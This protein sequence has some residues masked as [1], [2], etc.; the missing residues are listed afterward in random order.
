M[1]FI[2]TQDAAVVNTVG[3]DQAYKSQQ[4]EVTKH[5]E[6]GF[7]ILAAQRYL[8]YYNTRECLSRPTNDYVHVHTRRNCSVK[9]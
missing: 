4:H 7:T 1:H 8:P 6:T 3:P 2:K 5:R 9:L